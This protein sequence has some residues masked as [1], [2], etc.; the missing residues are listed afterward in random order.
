MPEEEVTRRDSLVFVTGNHRFRIADKG[1]TEVLLGLRGDGR[2]V[3]I[4]RIEKSEDK[5]IHE[6]MKVLREKMYNSRHVVQYVDYTEDQEFAYIAMQLCEYNLEEYIKADNMMTMDK[7]R[8]IVKEFLMG[9]K[10][11]H[12]GKTIQRDIKPS[13]VLIDKDGCVRLADFGISRTLDPDQS[14]IETDKA[15]TKCWE[16]TEIVAKSVGWRYKRSTD[17][18]VAGMLVYY[19]L[20]G[21]HHP[22]GDDFHCQANIA[23][24]K[25]SLDPL[26]DEEAKDL[27]ESMIN[28]FNPKLRPRIYDILEHPFF[29]DENRHRTFL[30]AVGEVDD[31][32]KHLKFTADEDLDSEMKDK[33]FSTWKTEVTYAKPTPANQRCPTYSA[34]ASP[35]QSQPQA[36]NH[37]NEPPRSL[38]VKGPQGVDAPQGMPTPKF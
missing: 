27:V 26:M 16:A 21:G 28:P 36:A 24:G 3:A 5:K 20:S 4:K 34:L 32:E 1:H 15:G 13:N 25:Y 29:W 23:D 22:F 37:C 14:T 2:E 18:Q 38:G 19:I 10:E 12:D 31:V 9:L 33:S 7:K 17:I 35:Q 8:N 6:E 30:K 11:L